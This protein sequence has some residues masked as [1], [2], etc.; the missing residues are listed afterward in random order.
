MNKEISKNRNYKIA[1]IPGDGT[2]PEVTEEAVKVLKTA[3]AKDGFKMDLTYFDFGGERYLKTKVVLTDEEVAGLRKFDTIL[4][5][6]MT[7]AWLPTKQPSSASRPPKSR[8]MSPI[9][10]GRMP[11]DAPPG[12]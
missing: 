5:D 4:C 10:A 8:G 1:V 11:P 2:G 6:R 3:A 12:K 9:S 7:T